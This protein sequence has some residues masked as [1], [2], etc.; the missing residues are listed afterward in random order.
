MGGR[1][2]Y[3]AGN[4]VAYAFKTV[5][6]INGVKVLEGIGGRHGLPAEA[7]RSTAYIVLKPKGPEKGVFHEMR[8]YDKDHYVVKEIAYHPEPNLNGG[9]HNENVLHIHDYPVRGNFDIRPAHRMTREE[10][11]TYKQYFEGVPEID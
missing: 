7:H 2:T 10:Y 4:N 9:N 8:I 1:G 3:A 6:I 11:E 5:R